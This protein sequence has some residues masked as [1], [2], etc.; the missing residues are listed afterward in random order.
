MYKQMAPQMDRT[1]ILYTN[2]KNSRGGAQFLAQINPKV[3]NIVPIHNKNSGGS[4]TVQGLMNKTIQRVVVSSSQP[5]S[6]Q[7]ASAF[8]QQQTANVNANSTPQSA[9]ALLSTNAGNTLIITTSTSDGSSINNIF[10]DINTTSTNANS[11][12]TN[13]STQA[14]NL[15]NLTVTASEK[16][17]HND[18]TSTSIN[19]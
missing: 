17:N 3:V 4:G 11:I 7:L 9:N 19:R 14:I 13:N 1:R 12:N 18:G 5:Q 2:L 10:N 16:L 6:Q 8:R 15:G